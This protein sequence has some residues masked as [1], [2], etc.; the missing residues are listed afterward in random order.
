MN[1]ALADALRDEPSVF[2]LDTGRWFA[3][4]GSRGWSQKLWYATKS[5][6]SPAVIEQAAA[7]IGAALD[8]IAG[9][10]RRLVMLDLDNV[11]WGGVVGEVDWTGINLGGHDPW[12]RRSPI[13]NVP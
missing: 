5:P 12:A 10:A 2:V 1:L 7:D 4:A 8:G 9:S 11:L 6:F 3:S 13:F